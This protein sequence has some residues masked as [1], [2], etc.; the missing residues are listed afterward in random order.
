M[1][2]K[3]SCW[4]V[5]VVWILVIVFLIIVWFVVNKME[6]NNVLNLSKNLFFV[7]VENFIKKEFFNFLGVFVL[8]IWYK[9][10]GL[11]IDDLKF[12]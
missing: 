3:V 6:V 5:I 11:N 9:D 1:I 4:V 2:G 8:F 10:L 7:E 12:I